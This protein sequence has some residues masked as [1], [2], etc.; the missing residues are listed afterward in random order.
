MISAIYSFNFVNLIVFRGC[1]R[2]V[3][4]EIRPKTKGEHDVEVM[5]PFW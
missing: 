2:L 4:N 1:I 5:L 3:R